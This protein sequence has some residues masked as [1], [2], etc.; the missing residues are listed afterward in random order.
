MATVVVPTTTPTTLPAP[1][2]TPR[3]VS[4]PMHSREDFVPRI[5]IEVEYKTG[6]VAFLVARGHGHGLP[7]IPVVLGSQEWV[8]ER[9]TEKAGCAICHGR[10]LRGEKPWMMTMVVVGTQTTSVREDVVEPRMHR[11][12]P[13]KEEEEEMSDMIGEDEIGEEEKKASAWGEGSE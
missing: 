10:C 11:P 13:C 12:W 6:P 2:G 5:P 9:W 8:S 7:A 4:I 1:K 3:T